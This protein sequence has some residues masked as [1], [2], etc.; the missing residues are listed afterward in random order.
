MQLSRLAVGQAVNQLW[1]IIRNISEVHQ[2]GVPLDF[3]NLIA[4]RETKR[5]K[6]HTDGAS[7]EQD[8]WSRQLFFL[9]PVLSRKSVGSETYERKLQQGSNQLTAK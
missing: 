5:F 3:S 2:Y 8:C 1:C 7:H 6:K 9:F 4:S